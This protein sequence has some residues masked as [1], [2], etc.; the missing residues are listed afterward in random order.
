MHFPALYAAVSLWNPW[1]DSR[2]GLQKEEFR[3]AWRNQIVEDQRKYW[4]R[5]SL[6]KR[7]PPEHPVVAEYV[8]RTLSYLVEWLPLSPDTKL[9]EI[10][11]GDG[12]FTTPLNRRC[13][14]V[15]VDFSTRMLRQNKAPRLAQMDANRLGFADNVFDVA[16]CTH[17]L[18]HISDIDVVLAE[19]KRV[20]RRYLVLLEPNR[21]N[22]LMFLFGLL[23]PEERG[24]LR[25]SPSYLEARVKHQGF[26]VVASFCYGFDMSN[27]WPVFLLPLVRKLGFSHFLGTCQLLVAERRKQ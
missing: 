16:F 27:R 14:T 26:H 24:S 11:C 15:G 23:V 22:P 9:L 19:C 2:S 8:D 21:R 20:S 5:E 12:R 13:W 10:G 18:H 25:F 3:M 6:R 1:A 4:E 7:R 17:V